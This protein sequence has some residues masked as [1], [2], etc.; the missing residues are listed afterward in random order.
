MGGGGVR[1]KCGLSGRFPNPWPT[2]DGRVPLDLA[3]NAVC[4]LI[5]RAANVNHPCRPPPSPRPPRGATGPA[6]DR[7][8]Q[9]KVPGSPLD[10][11]PVIGLL[12]Q[13]VQREVE[14]K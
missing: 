9:K 1:N 8:S 12:S 10:R 13:G 6:K 11:Y 7:G 3:S 2:E 4:C 5:F 14:K